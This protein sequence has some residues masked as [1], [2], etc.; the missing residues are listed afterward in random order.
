[1]RSLEPK[2]ARKLSA[3]KMWYAAQL[4][5]W[6][7]AVYFE[8][9]HAYDDDQTGLPVFRDGEFIGWLYD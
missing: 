2:F 9:L 4:R 1:M 5:A 3:V 6:G 7:V 8:N